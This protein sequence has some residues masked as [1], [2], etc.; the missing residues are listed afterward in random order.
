M[1]KHG[2]EGSSYNYGMDDKD[3]EISQHPNHKRPRRHMLGESAGHKHVGAVGHVPHGE[4]HR[5]HNA[6]NEGS[7]SQKVYSGS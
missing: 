5:Q 7:R 3:I 6:T 1:K 4:A 2:M